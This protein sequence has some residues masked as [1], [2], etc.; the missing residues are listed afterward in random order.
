[1]FGMN[2]A[3]LGIIGMALGFAVGLLDRPVGLLIMGVAWLL[4]ACGW[5]L[6]RRTIGKSGSGSGQQ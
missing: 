5:F 3:L 2:L 6:H 1:M 4:A